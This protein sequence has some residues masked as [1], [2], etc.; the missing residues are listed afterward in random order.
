M[1]KSAPVPATEGHRNSRPISFVPV[2][3]SGSVFSPC[4]S[5][6]QVFLRFVASV[7]RTTS[8]CERLF[9][10]NHAGAFGRQGA[11]PEGPRLSAASTLT[12]SSWA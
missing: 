2:E 10:S 6:F 7:S 9:I 12:A 3:P 1:R 4:L 5:R 8:R 11:A